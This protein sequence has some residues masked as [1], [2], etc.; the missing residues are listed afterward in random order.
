MSQPT[1]NAFVFFTCTE[2]HEGYP[3]EVLLR[4]EDPDRFVPFEDPDDHPYV[5]QTKRSWGRCGGRIVEYGT[6]T[7]VSDRVRWRGQC[8]RCAEVHWDET[9]ARV[10]AHTVCEGCDGSGF[11]PITGGRSEVP[12]PASLPRCSAC[13]QSHIGRGGARIKPRCPCT[14]CRG[15]GV[16]A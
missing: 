15:A 4:D 3:S 14:A 12:G 13:N 6:T 5:C 1:I 9:E 7:V 11:A 16:S 8:V 2:G 10:L